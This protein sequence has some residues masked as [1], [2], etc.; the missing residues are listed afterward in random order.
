[1]RNDAFCVFDECGIRL[2]D[3]VEKIIVM[4]KDQ[5][6]FAN[7]ATRIFHNP[8]AK[9]LFIEDSVIIEIIIVMI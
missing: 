5:H 3:T 6:G 2:T 8:C 1:M 7:F 4:M 9:Q